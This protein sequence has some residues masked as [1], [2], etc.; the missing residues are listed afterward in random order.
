M[1]YLIFIVLISSSFLIAQSTTI[2]SCEI[3]MAQDTICISDLVQQQIVKAREKQY[4]Q[5]V[6]TVSEAK[7][8]IVPKVV[9]TSTVNDPIRNFVKT[10]PIHIRIFIVTSFLIFMGLLIRRAVLVIKRRSS[11]ILKNKISSL[12][13]EKVIVKINSKLKDERKKLKDRKSIFNASEL[14]LASRLKLFEI[15]KM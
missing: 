9:V 6:Q 8:N 7:I 13:E 14:L 4:Q 3:E 5:I 11:R 10:L 12:R 2:D 1:K 15:G